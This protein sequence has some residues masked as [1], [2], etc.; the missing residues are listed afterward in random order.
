MVRL[1]HGTMSTL[2][3]LPAFRKSL[4]RW[5]KPRGYYNPLPN[6]LLFKLDSLPSPRLYNDDPNTVVFLSSQFLSFQAT[7]RSGGQGDEFHQGRALEGC[8]VVN[9]QIG[10]DFKKKTLTKKD[11]TTS[12][13]FYGRKFYTAPT[14]LKR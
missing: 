11:K 2:A 4:S 14:E 3:T 6:L 10:L 7:S 9:H 12:H 13:N 5:C 8:V 1:Q